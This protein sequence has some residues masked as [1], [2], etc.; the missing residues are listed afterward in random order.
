MWQVSHTLAQM[1]LPLPDKL[2]VTLTVADDA[3]VPIALMAATEQV[4]CV[5]LV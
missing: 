2:G 1:V 3:P 5:L 4:Y